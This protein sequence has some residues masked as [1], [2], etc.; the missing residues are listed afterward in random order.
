M[1]KGG[2]WAVRL[3]QMEYAPGH[4]IEDAICGQTDP[5]IFFPEKGV[6]GA[7]A[8]LICRRCP[9]VNQCLD[10]AV[11]APMLLEGVWGGT[12][13]LQRREMRR[14]LG[15]RALKDD[16]VCGTEAGARRHYRR[17]EPVCPPCRRAANVA[18]KEREAGA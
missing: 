2:G 3:M 13:A 6:S 11:N 15:I 7:A 14:Q 10:Y 4:W 1:R 8:K 18:R 5:E 9:V 12:T 17:K 16:D